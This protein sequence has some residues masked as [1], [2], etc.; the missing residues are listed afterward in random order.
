MNHLVVMKN[1]KIDKFINSTDKEISISFDFELYN[2]CERIIWTLDLIVNNNN[3]SNNYSK[4]LR[5]THAST[6]YD[7]YENEKINIG[8]FISQVK[9]YIDG[10]LIS[11]VNNLSNQDYSKVTN[12]INLYKYTSSPDTNKNYNCNSFSLQPN[13]SQPSGALNMSMFKYFT[14]KIILNKHTFIN[15]LKTLKSLYGYKNITFSLNLALNNY[16]IIRYQSGMSGLLFI[17]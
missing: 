6:L 5:S 12:L 13:D 14:I 17:K 2:L 15:Y 1:Y 11:S 4:N 8:N 10:A 7:I 9:L 3:L 16:N